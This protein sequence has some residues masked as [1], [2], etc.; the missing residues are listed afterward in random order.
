MDSHKM[1][2]DCMGWDCAFYLLGWLGLAL[3]VLTCVPAFTANSGE[4]YSPAPA[5]Y[6]AMCHPSG[7]VRP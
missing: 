1:T 7:T 3:L 6:L 4:N 5:Q 2:Y